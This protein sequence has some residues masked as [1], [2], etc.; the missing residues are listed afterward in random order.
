MNL[1]FQFAGKFILSPESAA[2]IPARE[3]PAPRRTYTYIHIHID[4]LIILQSLGDR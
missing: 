2:D 1:T 3:I 4:F